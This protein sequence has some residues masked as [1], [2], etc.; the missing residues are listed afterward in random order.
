[1]NVGAFV[2][3]CGGSCAIDLEAVRDGVRDV[4][5]VASSELLCSDGLPGMRQVIDEYELDQLIVTTPEG[6]CQRRIRDVAEESGLHPEATAFVDHREGAAWV[7]E[8]PEAT[9]KVAR[10]LNRTYAGLQAESVSRTIS[11]EAGDHVI[12]VGD[13]E[14]AA[15]L[16]DTATV[17]LV[18]AGREFADPDV[19]LD[20]VTLERGHVLNVEGRYG[21]FEL[22]L[23]ARVTDDCIGCMDCVEEGPE[24]LVTARPVDISPRADDGEWA[25][26][27]PTDAIEMDGVKRTLIADQIVYP[28]Y[29]DAPRAGTLGLH[30]GPVDAG[31]V[32]D[33]EAALSGF[34][35]PQYLDLEM[36]VCAAGESSQMGCN[37]CV[38]A[39]PHGAVERSTIDSV[40]FDGMACADCGACTS[41]CPTGAVQLREP[42]NERLA[43]EVEALL[44]DE[45]DEGGWLPFDGA[46][47]IEEP[48]VAFVCSE[49][50]ERTLREHGRRA[51]DDPE[52]DY[53]PVLPV[54]VNCTDTVGEAHVL[55][56]LAAGAEGVTIVGCGSGCL[57][58]GPDPKAALVERLNRATTDLGLGE[59]VAFLAPTPGEPATFTADLREFVDGVESTPIPTGEHRAT[60]S[61]D[62]DRPNPPFDTHGWALESV[63]EILEHAEPEREVIRGL[64]TFGRMRVSEACNLTPTCTTLC[65]TDA[66]Q[67][68]PEGELQFNHERCVNCG[69]CEE[70]CPETAITMETGLSL[71]LLPE[72]NDGDPW[73][74]VYEGE[75]LEC[76]RC[77]EPFTSRGSMEKV[78]EEVGGLVEGIA[79]DSEHSVFEYCDTCRAELVYDRG[80]V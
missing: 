34:E 18:A 16:S 30:T 15:A 12:V 45:N 57:H 77:G 76:V 29:D 61:I 55:H 75:M 37:A 4:D 64:E 9:D 11:R 36:D 35:K 58:S 50:A 28:G 3:T 53:P 51:R 59:R 42:S 31:T 46:A 79:P 22:A 25:D 44:D 17:S 33:V 80:G 14:T 78:R 26:C 49:R 13:A 32:A 71:S 54:R 21:E 20:D 67:R 65:P 48:V 38:E 5:V 47:G 73:A 8:E 41:S 27:C 52:L 2:C 23:A 63:R 40:A 62:A 6:S 24:G 68:T 69:L 72:R 60:G 56:A 1:M 7:H 10:L 66:I 43:R 70:G 74:T 19:D 39:C